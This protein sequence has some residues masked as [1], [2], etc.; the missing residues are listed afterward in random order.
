MKNKNRKGFTLAETLITLSILGVVA[1]VMVPSIIR[2][3][4]KRITVT[5]LQKVMQPLIKWQQI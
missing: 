5:K 4:Q 3:Y 2:N 1:V